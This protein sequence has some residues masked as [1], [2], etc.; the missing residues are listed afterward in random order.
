MGIFGRRRDANHWLERGRSCLLQGKGSQAESAFGHVLREQPQHLE[1]LKGMMESWLL[2]GKSHGVIEQFDSLP[3]LQQ[4]RWQ[5][6]LL[7]ALAMQVGHLKVEGYLD[8]LRLPRESS[9]RLSGIRKLSKEYTKCGALAIQW[10]ESALLTFHIDEANQALRQ[11]RDAEPRVSPKLIAHLYAQRDALLLK[12]SPDIEQALHKA[13]ELKSPSDRIQ[14]L[15][16]F[17]QESMSLAPLQ[18]DIGLAFFENDE[19]E[20]AMRFLNRAVNANPYWVNAWVELGLAGIAS[21]RLVRSR[22]ALF[23]AIYLSDSPWVGQLHEEIEIKLIESPELSR[24]EPA[25]DR[26]MV[27]DPAGSIEGLQRAL[28][29][30]DQR[31][32]AHFLMGRA[33]SEMGELT[34]SPMYLRDALSLVQDGEEDLK[35]KIG[36]L[37]E[38]DLHQK[39]LAL[40]ADDWAEEA[41]DLLGEALQ[42][43]A[44][45]PLLEECHRISQ[46]I[47]QGELAMEAALLYEE[48]RPGQD[49]LPF[50]SMR[51][52]RTALVLAPD[53]PEAKMTQ[54][55]LV[56]LAGDHAMA[57]TEIR[58]LL[59]S[60]LPLSYVQLQLAGVFFQTNDFE[61]ADEY[62]LKSSQANIEPWSGIASDNLNLLHSEN[63]GEIVV[64]ALPTYRHTA[65]FKPERR[66]DGMSFP[67]QDNLFQISP[68]MEM[69]HGEFSMEEAL[70]KA[71]NEIPK[72]SDI[73]PTGGGEVPDLTQAESVSPEDIL[74]ETESLSEVSLFDRPDE[75]KKTNADFPYSTGRSSTEVPSIR[76]MEQSGDVPL[77]DVTPSTEVDE[78]LP[79]AQLEEQAHVHIPKFSELL[80]KA[81]D[82]G[83]ETSGGDVAPGLSE[84]P[85]ADS[86]ESTA[87]SE[88]SE[89][90]EVP[91]PFG[92]RSKF[93]AWTPSSQ[94]L[95]AVEEKSEVESKP[96]FTLPPP[97]FSFDS[98]K[99]S[100]TPSPLPPPPFAQT[101]TPAPPSPFG[102]ASSSRP[103][104]E[105][106]SL[107]PE[108]MPIPSELAPPE[109]LSAP[110]VIP[111]QEGAATESAEAEPLPL[112][113]AP[114]AMADSQSVPEP[115]ADVEIPLPP[116]PALPPVAEEPV[117]TEPFGSNVTAL[118]TDTEVAPPELPPPPPALPPEP[119]AEVSAQAE[120]S[121]SPV[122]ASPMVEVEVPIPVATTPAADVAENVVPVPE[123]VQAEVTTASVVDSQQ[124]A[125]ESV[126]EAKD[127][128]PADTSTVTKAPQEAKPAPSFSSL[129][130][131]DLFDDQND[132]DLFLEGAFDS[133]ESKDD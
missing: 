115:V 82:A 54:A 27:G 40:V 15:L 130:N 65:H 14:L 25:L 111:S 56:A 20:S 1:A 118:A 64:Y 96:S 19:P 92:S 21:G 5:E 120:V 29:I 32:D 89:D 71:A 45:M 22:E 12:K 105:T 17:A 2:Q 55:V 116:P 34:R 90:S 91:A 132:L 101:T 73:A 53:F 107:V 99:E 112:P 63:G 44:T 3:T 86:S 122:E 58:E 47:H 88:Q 108:E 16:P 70:E 43:D 93:R 62:W 84:E 128:E 80:A 68:S 59:T 95:D 123:P 52:I 74:N 67:S 113:P 103:S 39:Y 117:V 109:E 125:S 46:K 98:S 83:T 100:S 69:D 131:L 7:I 76:S 78:V 9:K 106:V 36:S 121:D 11:L 51:T 102:G 75:K 30:N 72:F 50:E 31:A 23:R 42:M 33:Y 119:V 35:A 26:L 48:G 77:F 28:E 10:V 8:W 94:T 81:E 60:S 114:I 13:S 79:T 104:L 124:A 87:P 4:E 85:V 133:L 49:D 41:V 110:T 127:T 97:P 57:E 61:L 24:M 18:R 37:L 6:L 129:D 38:H 126:V 66:L